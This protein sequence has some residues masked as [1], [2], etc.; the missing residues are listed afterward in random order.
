MGRQQ[1]GRPFQHFRECRDCL[2]QLPGENCEAL[3][4]SDPQGNESPRPCAEV[5]INGRCDAFVAA[6]KE[7]AIYENFS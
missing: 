4:D 2:F 3:T 5:N 7:G 6:K 1:T